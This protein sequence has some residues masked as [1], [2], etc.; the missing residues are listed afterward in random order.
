MHRTS[1][2]FAFVLNNIPLFV[3]LKYDKL[4]KLS[5]DFEPYKNLWVTSSDWMRWHDSWMNDP[6]SGIDAENIERNA[7]DAFKAMHKA[8]KQFQDFESKLISLEPALFW[9][10]LNSFCEWVQLT[11]HIKWKFWIQD[12]IHEV[13]DNPGMEHPFHFIQ[14]ELEEVICMFRLTSCH[15]TNEY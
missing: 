1:V 8:I 6:I 7:T 5:K 11:N 12:Q 15:E 13:L 14:M 9:I 4:A 3:C 2:V 10:N